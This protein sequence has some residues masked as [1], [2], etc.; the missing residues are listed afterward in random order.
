MAYVYVAS[1]PSARAS[2]RASRSARRRIMEHEKWVQGRQRE[3]RASTPAMEAV[4]S[5]RIASAPLAAVAGS[6]RCNSS[7]VAAASA[8]TEFHFQVGPHGACRLYAVGYVYM[9]MWS[10][11]Q[12]RGQRGLAP[13]PEHCKAVQRRVYE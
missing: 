4:E 7:E 10:W 6:A 1:S 13:N 2:A 12:D 8:D 3:W 5:Q 11:R 9:S